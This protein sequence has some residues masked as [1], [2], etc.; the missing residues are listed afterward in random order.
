MQSPSGSDMSFSDSDKENVPVTLIHRSTNAPN[1]YS[2]Q[3]FGESSSNIST[4]PS[5]SQLSLHKDK[6]VTAPL[7]RPD[8]KPLRSIVNTPRKRKK[9]TKP[10]TEHPIDNRCN[11]CRVATWNV[12]KRLD[13]ISILTIMIQGNISILSC[14]EP[15]VKVADAWRHK[16]SAEMLENGVKSIWSKHQCVFCFDN[17]Y[18]HRIVKTQIYF[19]GRIVLIVF[20]LGQGANDTLVIISVYNVCKGSKSFS[21]GTSRK[22]LHQSVYERVRDTLNSLQQSHPHAPILFMGDLQSSVSDTSRDKI[23]K[24]LHTRDE[25]QQSNVDSDIKCRTRPNTSRNMDTISSSSTEFHQSKQKKND[26]LTLVL[27]KHFNMTSLVRKY[28]S[29]DHYLTFVHRNSSHVMAHGIDHICGNEVAKD[30]CRNAGIDTVVSMSSIDS[31]HFIIYVDLDL[32]GSNICNECEYESENILYQKI[33]NIKI[34]CEHSNQSQNECEHNI[35]EYNSDSLDDIE[36]SFDDTQFLSEKV[37][38]DKELFEKV[39]SLT[40]NKSLIN[41]RFIDKALTILDQLKKQIVRVV[42]EN[43]TY[44]QSP[45]IVNRR[46]IWKDRINTCYDILEAA[47][48]E[49]LLQVK[50]VHSKSTSQQRTKGIKQLSQLGL[51]I[52]P[53]DAPLH[54]AIRHTKRMITCSIRNLNRIKKLIHPWMLPQSDQRYSKPCITIEQSQLIIKLHTITHN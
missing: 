20:N 29:S 5:S 11:K 25:H 15:Y 31:D 14:Q 24:V 8:T 48:K 46:A 4:Y 53:R 51:I 1:S 27:S 33:A 44:N 42:Q 34:K 39:R 40:S 2:C 38:K 9:T 28:S 50:L 54:T 23:Y 45:H 6:A 13:H 30:L 16:M 37:K 47:M 19:E 35:N 32:N 36:F 21:D 49:V 3:P 7:L 41:L 10:A 22:D 43:S 17:T 52:L 26:I 12:N 18:A